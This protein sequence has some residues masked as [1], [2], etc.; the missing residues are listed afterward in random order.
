MGL[1]SGSATISFRKMNGLG[2]DFVVVDARASPVDLT[3]DEV[4]AIADRSRGIGC[5][6]LIALEPSG[7]ADVFMRIY[8]ADGSEVDACGNA[9]RCVAFVLAQ[10]TGREEVSIETGA[11]IL[12]ADA[13]SAENVTIDMGE[14]R[15]AWDAIPLAEPFHDTTGIELQIGPI[16]APV[17]HSPSVVNVGNPHAIF[18]VDDVDAHDLAR[19]GPLLENHP[20][21]P[22]RANITLAQIV[23]PT[24]LKI[25]TWERGAGLTK[26]CGTAACAAAVAAAR[27][28]LSERRV[29][30]DLPGGGR[31]LV[32]W[33]ENGHI[34][35]SGPAELEF[36]GVL[37]R[38]TLSR[39]AV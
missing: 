12:K 14:P 8:N 23:S 2:N 21:F 39:A 28:G 6:Q 19:F 4:R 24:G 32:D 15:F 27:K 13:K 18:W 22:K 34:L 33:A 20:V 37:E 9:A 31:L 30:V 25:R 1:M 3:E 36:E 10:E 5:D 35:M 7:K 17:L 38:E 11:G 16:D 29:H 26:A